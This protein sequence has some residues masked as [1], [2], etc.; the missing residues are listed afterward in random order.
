M[1]LSQVPENSILIK[2]IQGSGDNN[3]NKKVEVKSRQPRVESVKKFVRKPT[4]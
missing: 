1:Y 2:E 3:E 4:C